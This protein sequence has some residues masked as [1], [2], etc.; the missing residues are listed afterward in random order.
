[1]SEG[2]SE[3]FDHGEYVVNDAVD[4]L[5]TV[6]GE[7]ALCVFDDAWARPKRGDAFGNDRDE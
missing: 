4:Q 2:G 5:G 1:M 3:R 6:R 7:A